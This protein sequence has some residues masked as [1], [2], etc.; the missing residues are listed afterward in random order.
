[1]HIKYR[2]F[3]RAGSWHRW[4]GGWRD[5]WWGPGQQRM[6]IYVILFNTSDYWLEKGRSPTTFSVPSVVIVLTV[7]ISVYVMLKPK[8]CN[9]HSGLVEG[10][11]KVFS[12]LF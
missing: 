4:V 9:V 11:H 3:A 12:Q 2:V 1:M 6:Q 5:A 7:C 8:L 10:G